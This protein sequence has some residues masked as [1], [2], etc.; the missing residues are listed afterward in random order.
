M[1]SVRN[2]VGH[3]AGGKGSGGSPAF[4][5]CEPFTP[6]EQRRGGVGGAWAKQSLSGNMKEQWS[7][8]YSGQGIPGGLELGFVLQGGRRQQK[9]QC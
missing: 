6:R 3:G 8:L 4:S 9:A 7:G 5:A 2:C 1:F